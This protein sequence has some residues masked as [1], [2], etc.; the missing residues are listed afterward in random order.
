M[1]TADVDPTVIY[2]YEKREGG[3]VQATRVLSTTVR[4]RPVLDWQ[5]TIEAGRYT[6]TRMYLGIQGPYAAM[7]ALRDR[8]D[9]LDAAERIGRMPEPLRAP[10]GALLHFVAVVPARLRGPYAEYREG[11]TVTLPAGGDASL[12]GSRQAWARRA[13]DVEAEMRHRS[14]PIV[15]RLDA[16]EV[17]TSL[18]AMEQLLVLT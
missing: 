5:K 1:R 10:G 15:V 7:I 8:I 9:A 4:V 14:L 2:A 6:G 17:V 13:L 18:P 16:D 11:D 3:G 12:D